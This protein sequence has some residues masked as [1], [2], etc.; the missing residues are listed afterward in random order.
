M[1]SLLEPS[2]VYPTYNPPLPPP[3]GPQCAITRGAQVG[4]TEGGQAYSGAGGGQT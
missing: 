3:A 2:L 1:F 4:Q